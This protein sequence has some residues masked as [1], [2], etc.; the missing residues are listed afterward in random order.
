VVIMKR[1]E[2][3]YIWIDSLCIIQQ[4]PLLEDWKR[5]APQMA[6]VYSN[7]TINIAATG[8]RDSSVGLFFPRGDP[9]RRLPEICLDWSFKVKSSCRYT[10]LDYNYWK[11][12]VEDDPLL[13][14]AWVVQ[15]RLLAPR[16]LH[17][18]SN[19]L[20]WE[21]KEGQIC[22]DFPIG[23][24]AVLLRPDQDCFFKVF[25]DHI[26][27]FLKA[28][29]SHP[30]AAHAVWQRA[31]SSYTGCGL[32]KSS[33]KLIALAGI[34]TELGPKLSNEY[35]AGLWKQYMATEML[36][37]VDVGTI[38]RRQVTY[39]APSFSWASVDGA[40]V[41][42]V[43]QGENVLVEVLE[44][45][46]QAELFSPFG[47]VEGGFVRLRGTLKRA[48]IWLN[49]MYDEGQYFARNARARLPTTQ[50]HG[51]YGTTI[52]QSMVSEQRWLLK[53]E[54]VYAPTNIKPPWPTYSR[55]VYRDLSSIMHKRLDELLNADEETGVA[56]ETWLMEG[57]DVYLDEELFHGHKDPPR[58]VFI[59]LFAA[60]AG[61][62][63]PL[64]GLIIEPT[65]RVDGEYR[66]LGLFM[67]SHSVSMNV[68]SVPHRSEATIPCERYE[69]DTHKH[70]IVLV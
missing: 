8:A 48:S 4:E 5:E 46:T 16:V 1:L 65:G 31:L 13:R 43:W 36:W 20:F 7:A 41:P 60:Q 55:Q 29:S 2:L 14:R 17:F 39:R 51:N 11:H 24:P 34:A 25:N 32:T 28:K 58:Q 57:A 53:L 19:Q 61:N 33:D 27:D 10:M 63:M 9:S 12:L 54:D 59:M 42:G 3:D 35:V 23:S 44:A 64:R 15:E 26:L 50:R 66:R 49:T 62:S 30:N 37:Y 67:T 21:C 18:G 38:S 6:K 70:T 45:S 68:I 22:E 40:V 52:S 56:E 47:P 69:P